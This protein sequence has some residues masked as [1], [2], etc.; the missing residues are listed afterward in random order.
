M[1]K[2]LPL[3]LL[4]DCEILDFAHRSSQPGY[5]VYIRQP[6]PGLNI[7]HSRSARG[8]GYR[9]YELQRHARRRLIPR[10]RGPP[11][12]IQWSQEILPYPFKLNEEFHSSVFDLS[13]CG[14]NIMGGSGS[15]YPALID[16]GAHWH[17]VCC[18]P[19]LLCCDSLSQAPVASAS[20]MNSL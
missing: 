4:R 15:Q 13:V 17:F 7:L 6:A 3:M 8:W 19:W 12:T 11:P 9:H 20:P 2:Y 16:T 10:V 18:I 5:R 1:S 14:T